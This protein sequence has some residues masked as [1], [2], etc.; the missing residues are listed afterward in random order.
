MCNAQ[1][2]LKKYVYL[3]YIKKSIWPPEIPQRCAVPGPQM[4]SMERTVFS[5]NIHYQI[6]H[7]K[8][9]SLQIAHLRLIMDTHLNCERITFRNSRDTELLLFLQGC[10]TNTSEGQLQ[11][12]GTFNR[13]F[14]EF[15]SKKTLLSYL[16][17]IQT[18]F[19]P[20]FCQAEVCTL[21]FRVQM[22]F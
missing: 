18:Y 9:S 12:R 16:G 8:G 2:N 10:P 6:L 13:Q 15:K 14:R 17:H 11:K 5:A 1:W 21:K 22:D 4:I 20:L 3:F 7:F 19:L